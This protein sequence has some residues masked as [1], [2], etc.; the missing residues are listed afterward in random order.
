MKKKM[1][2]AIMAMFLILCI[3]PAR[4]ESAEIAIDC[5]CAVLMDMNTKRVLYEKDSHKKQP[6]ASMTKIMT[7][8]IAMEYLDEGRIT[9]EDSVI[10]SQ[11]ASAM[12]GTRLFLEANEVRTVDDLLYGIAIESGNDAAVALAEFIGG[13][14]EG[15]I[16]LMNEKAR[17]LGMDDSYFGTPCGLEDKDNY[18]CAYDTA[19]MSAELLKHERIYNYISV[20]TKEVT[21]GRNNDVKRVLANTN[22]LLTQTDYVDGI[23]TGY[24][25]QSGY[26]LSATA[27]KGDM[28]LIAVVMNAQ[29]SAVRFTDTKT[30]LIYGMNSFEGKYIIKPGD[31]VCAAPILNAENPTS[32]LAV[33]EGVYSLSEAGKQKQYEEKTEI[34]PSLSAPIDG[35]T[36]VGKL[37]ITSNEEVFTLDLYPSA[38]IEKCTFREFLRRIGEYALY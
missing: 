28:R 32:E 7:M 19:L 4:V 1:I 26:C 27:K 33:R 15:F 24:T 3:F 35:N 8:L 23:K 38:P 21:V 9:P 13:S 29:S 11:R 34:F 18:S 5:P 6:I 17:Q 10:I 30:L 25:S 16:E 37:T 12:G 14:Y 31:T 22:K 2:P 36:P 20:W